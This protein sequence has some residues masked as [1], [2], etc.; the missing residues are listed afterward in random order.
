PVQFNAVRGMLGFTGSYKG[1]SVSVMGS[2][3]GVPSI[4]IYSYELFEF[5]GVENIIRIG[6]A[7]GIADNLKV[8]DIVIAMGAS[9]NSNFANQYCL[10]GSF[11]P[12][13]D[14]ALLEKAIGAA[15]KNGAN[16][17]VGNI[18]T[19]DTFYGDDATAMENWRKMGILAVEMEAAGLY[20]TAARLGKSAL[21]ILTVSDL[22]FTGESATSAE[23]QESFTNMM[24]IALETAV[25]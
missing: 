5:Y 14:F 11:A 4:G 22:I 7:G 8:R 21:C 2:G 1:H 16:F 18:L 12:L 9:T 15:R 23:R 25:S 13:A 17:A 6:T 19:S 10:N 3:M 20:A 24:E